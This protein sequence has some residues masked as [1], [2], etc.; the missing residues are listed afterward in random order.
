MKVKEESFYNEIELLVVRRKESVI[1]F[2][3][4]KIIFKKT[5][6]FLIKREVG[7]LWNVCNLGINGS[8][9]GLFIMFLRCYKKIIWSWG[10]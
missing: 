7:I 9:G 2:K 4:E 10:V 3:G 5:K 6:V 1:E 8:L